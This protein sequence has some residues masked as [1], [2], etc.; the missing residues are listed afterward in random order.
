MNRNESESD[1][2]RQP[3]QSPTLNSVGLVNEIVQAGG[4]KLTAPA[5]D[6]GEDP[7]KPKGV[8]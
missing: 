3:W 6:A 2:N 8:E 5:V 1:T 4:G 7:R